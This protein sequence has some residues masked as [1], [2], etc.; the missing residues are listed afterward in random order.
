MKF[1]KEEKEFLKRRLKLDMENEDLFF[2]SSS[3]TLAN[4]IMES[5]KIKY[6]EKAFDSIHQACK[7]Y[8]KDQINLMKSIVRKLK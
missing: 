8:N 5:N 6:S 1:T 4:I 3:F 7:K 2:K